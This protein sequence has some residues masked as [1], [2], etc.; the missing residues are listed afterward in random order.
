M[1]S[2]V[3]RFYN[4]TL[5]RIQ[6][7]PSK[8]LLQKK[9]DMH[10]HYKNEIII[11]FIYVLLS[12][13]FGIII[14]Y[15]KAD[16]VIWDITEPILRQ[17]EQIIFINIL[18]GFQSQIKVSI[19]VG[20]LCSLPTLWI[21]VS[22]F[23]SPAIY[24]KEFKFF[25]KIVIGSSISLIISIIF[26]KKWLFP[27][28]LH[29]FL[30]FQGYSNYFPSLIDY[31]DIFF[32]ISKILMITSQIPLFFFFLYFFGIIKDVFLIKYRR[33]FIL[34]ILLWSAFTTPPDFLSL[35]IVFVPIFFIYEFCLFFL[36]VISYK[37]N[38]IKNSNGN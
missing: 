33:F 4:N 37:K 2:T 15:I 18:D 9:Q 25:I 5:V 35:I 23:I 21:Q 31:L 13:I 1:R 11:R 20:I 6:L 10:N 17:K 22:F 16:L 8:N 14:V 24:Q 38:I 30:D 36:F 32:K 7:F 3:N 12:I 29:F 34:S 19:L 26:L 27:K 28:I